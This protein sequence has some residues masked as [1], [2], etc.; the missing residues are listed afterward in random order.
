MIRLCIRPE[1]MGAADKLRTGNGPEIATVETVR[2]IAEEQDLAS[3]QAIAALPRRHWTTSAIV[4]IG[5]CRQSFVD[6]DRIAQAAHAIAIDS[7]DWLHN[8]VGSVEIAAMVGKSGGVSG[9][10]DEDEVVQLRSPRLNAIETDWDAR[11]G[12]P[13]E[14]GR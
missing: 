6:Q 1:Q 8:I 5:H 10:V 12:I 4:T 3:R 13:N 14:D 2:R 11:R 9:Q 7:C